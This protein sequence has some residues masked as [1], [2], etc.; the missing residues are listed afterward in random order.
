[1]EISQNNDSVDKEDVKSNTGDN[2][3]V[4]VESKSTPRAKPLTYNIAKVKLESNDV[5]DSDLVS[6]ET[7]ATGAST[8]ETTGPSISNGQVSM[9]TQTECGMTVKVEEDQ[10]RR[11]EVKIKKEEMENYTN[12]MEQS[13]EVKCRQDKDTEMNK[14]IKDSIKTERC[15]NADIKSK[16]SISEGS[17]WEKD[18]PSPM[19]EQTSMD[20]FVN[21]HHVPILEAQK[22]QDSRLELMEATAQERDEFKMKAQSLALELEKKEFTVNLLLKELTVKKEFSHQNI[23]TDP[24]DEKDYKTLY[25]QATQH[26]E[27]LIQTINELKKQQ[28]ENSQIL[29]SNKKWQ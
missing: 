1:M 28:E 21:E 13:S 12:V 24:V 27:Q 5:Q 3:V 16:P 20:S 6:M 4:I 10:Q 2:D 17:D 8:S 18:G 15:N 23:Q 29:V 22:Q 11:D 7:P 19:P 14:L 9:T 26:N 25:F